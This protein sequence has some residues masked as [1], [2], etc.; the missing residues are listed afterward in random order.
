MKTIRSRII[1]VAVA[2][3]A[4][5]LVAVCAIM[6]RPLVDVADGGL[7]LDESLP[8]AGYERLV[9]DEAGVLSEKTEQIISIYNANWSA[10]AGRVMAVV[11]AQ[12]VENAEETAWEWAEKMG[13]G[14]DDALVLVET[15]NG[16]CCTVVSQGTFRDDFDS[17]PGGFV[18]SLTYHTMKNRDFDMAVVN[19]FTR[20]HL[21]H[22]DHHEVVVQ[23][24]MR[25][26]IVIAVIVGLLLV[27]LIVLRAA[28]LR[29]AVKEERSGKNR[30]ITHRD[31][32]RGGALGSYRKSHIY[33][34]GGRDGGFGSSNQVGKFGDGNHR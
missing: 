12:S 14:A 33:G 3:A 6:N 1:A 25:I 7:A 8:T 15:S 16:G 10:M 22:N 23:S 9:V 27:V 29:R 4:I 32:Y 30:S 18:D 11:T 5:L 17:Q 19:V 26:G 31:A 2:V 20:V 13:L 28:D 21:F 34:K 24:G